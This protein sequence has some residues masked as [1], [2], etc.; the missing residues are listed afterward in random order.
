MC[1]EPIKSSHILSIA[2]QRS[3][4]NGSSRYAAHSCTRAFAAMSTEALST[5]AVCLDELSSELAALA[6]GHVLHYTCAK[7]ALQLFKQCPICRKS[8]K[9]AVRLFYSAGCS[10]LSTSSAP[11][12]SS[13]APSSPATQSD[14]VPQ[15]F[16]ALRKSIA[17][18]AADQRMVSS[19]SFRLESENVRLRQDVMRTAAQLDVMRIKSETQDK[20]LSV[21]KRIGTYVALCQLYTSPATLTSV[22]LV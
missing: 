9:H 17:R 8:A 3:A 11:A 5:C 15:T 12:T 2:N 20:E 19:R 18:L 10:S 14:T 22:V 6:C 1:D 7:Q 13:P 4:A 16:T 21:W